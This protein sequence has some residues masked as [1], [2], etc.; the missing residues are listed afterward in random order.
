LYGVHKNTLLKIRRKFCWVVRKYLQPIFIQSPN[1]S[2][3]RALPRRFE[4]LHGIPYVIR[5]IDGS[6]IPVQAH[7]VG[8]KKL[9]L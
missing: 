1:E 2:Q 6:H 3:F 8:G 7:V 5:T 4:K 9:L